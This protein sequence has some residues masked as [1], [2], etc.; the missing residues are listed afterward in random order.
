MP[1]LY[2]GG[3]NGGMGRLLL[4]RLQAVFRYL[5][6]VERFSG[7]D[8]EFV[9]QLRVQCRRGEAA[10]ALFRNWLPETQYERWRNRLRDYRRAATQAREM[11][12]M[13]ERLKHAAQ[14]RKK[15]SSGDFHRQSQKE[16]SVRRDLT[17]EEAAFCEQLRY[18]RFK[19]QKRLVRVIRSV[20]P[21]LYQKQVASL[22]KSMRWRGDGVE[23]T[24]AKIS[25]IQGLAMLR[26]L[27]SAAK[28]ASSSDRDA[29]GNR[30]YR[31][32][33]RMRI[34]GKKLRYVLDISKR[35]DG[36]MPEP[37]V[38]KVL[39]TMQ[40]KLGAINDH[41]SAAGLVSRLR[42]KSKCA[43][44]IE[45]L[46]NMQHIEEQ[47]AERLMQAFIRWWKRVPVD[48]TSI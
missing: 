1:V 28:R 35:G 27:V 29:Q 44:L 32:L 23:P 17:R 43:R 20:D 7:W 39:T 5:P 11:D 25:E 14:K 13:L 9:H 19:A 33:H 47:C 24:W 48:L 4:M 22:L 15:G 34:A 18:I 41:V 12:V 45:Y 40:A 30:I 3:Y 26:K 46:T 36:W 37:R 21:H 42:R 10:L 16:K 38:Q 8:T 31:R 6:L 2:C